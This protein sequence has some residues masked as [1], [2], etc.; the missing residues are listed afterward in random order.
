MRGRLRRAAHAV[1]SGAVCSRSVGVRSRHGWARFDCSG[2]GITAGR[3]LRAGVRPVVLHQRGS[4][5]LSMLE[6]PFV[7]VPALYVSKRDQRWDH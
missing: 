2:G 7:V 5:R 6:D 4:D 3:V 1:S